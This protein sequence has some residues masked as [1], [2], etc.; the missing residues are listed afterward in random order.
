MINKQS[1][2]D[3]LQDG[4]IEGIMDK[5]LDNPI[6]RGLFTVQNNS[7]LNY[8]ELHGPEGELVN[9]L[10]SYITEFTPEL[11]DRE[12]T[13]VLV[14]GLGLGVIPFVLQDFCTT[15]DVVE[16]STDII[17]ISTELGLLN[18]DVNIIEGDIFTFQP[19][20]T[21]DIVVMDIWYRPTTVEEVETLNFIYLP[22]VNEGGFIY[23]PI[24]ATSK[25]QRI[26]KVE[27]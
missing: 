22:F 24:N 10:A 21:Y 20:Q 1:L 11:L 12:F 15:V 27:R 5:V 23:Y 13:S 9:D 19:T 25:E 14:G 6:E 17:E 4:Q 2:L 18:S 8:L 26:S 16:N 7:Q 3:K